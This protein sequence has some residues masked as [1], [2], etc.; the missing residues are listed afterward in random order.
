[1]Q[2]PPASA[3]S[4]RESRSLF[5]KGC[6]DHEP[7]S[8]QQGAESPPVPRKRVLS[9]AAKVNADLAS[10]ACIEKE[11]KAEAELAASRRT[12]E[13]RDAEFARQLQAQLRQQKEL[14]GLP[15]NWETFIESDQVQPDDDLLVAK[16]LQ[17]EEDLKAAF[18]LQTREQG[19]D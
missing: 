13:K 10:Q 9:Y 16:R 19:K 14:E 15:A 18:D 2:R 7:G 12:M 5:E 8:K 6:P 4:V 1:M 11:F 3:G 17:E